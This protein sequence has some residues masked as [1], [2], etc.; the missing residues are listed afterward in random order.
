MT[1]LSVRVHGPRLQELGASA[2]ISNV[3][4]HTCCSDTPGFVQYVEVLQD[5]RLPVQHCEG[6]RSCYFL[7]IIDPVYSFLQI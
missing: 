4:R 7:V 5:G 1:C 3:V 2:P 6:V